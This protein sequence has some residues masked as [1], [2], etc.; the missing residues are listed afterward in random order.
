MPSI[1]DGFSKDPSKRFNEIVN[2]FLIQ[3]DKLNALRNMVDNPPGT[4][5]AIKKQIVIEK[6]KISEQIYEEA[7]DALFDGLDDG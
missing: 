7:M 2:M 3:P 6:A 4:I 1:S 5:D